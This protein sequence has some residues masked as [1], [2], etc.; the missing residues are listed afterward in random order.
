MRGKSTLADII[1]NCKMTSVMVLDSVMSFLRLKDVI[2]TSKHMQ[3]S[4][5]I[6]WNSSVQWRKSWMKLKT[7]K[8]V[9]VVYCGRI[10]IDQ[11]LCVN[12]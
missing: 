7:L 1:F 3:H 5:T 8:C 6:G 10:E 4:Q 11:L 12:G 2:N 9:F